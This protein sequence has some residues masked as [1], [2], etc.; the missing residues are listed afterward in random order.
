[1][2][3]GPGHLPGRVAVDGVWRDARLSAPISDT[4]WVQRVTDWAAD[5]GRHEIMVRATDVTGAV[6]AE[7]PSQPAPDGARGWHTISV[8][9]G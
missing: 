6:Q 3:P 7:Q 9:I 8:N 1:M 2:G 5:P 4:T